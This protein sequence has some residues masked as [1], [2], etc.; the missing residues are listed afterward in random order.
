MEEYLPHGGQPSGR[1]S[2]PTRGDIRS[3]SI[4]SD[5]ERMLICRP[6][7]CSELENPSE[8]R[9]CRNAMS[10]K[11]VETCVGHVDGRRRVKAGD[12]MPENNAQA[13]LDA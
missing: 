6:E 11:L 10:H 9:Q 13:E 1:S 8:E 7:L 4:Y 12:S 3:A 5:G 2:P